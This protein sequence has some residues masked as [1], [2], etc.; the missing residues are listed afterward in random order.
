MRVLQYYGQ[1]TTMTDEARNEKCKSSRRGQVNVKPHR[2]CLPRMDV[3]EQTAA[4]SKVDSLP[5]DNDIISSRSAGSKNGTMNK[6]E[7]RG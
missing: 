6:K 3:N 1:R 2:V 7:T 4:T 5:I